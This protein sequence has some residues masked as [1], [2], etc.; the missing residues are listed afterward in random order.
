MFVVKVTDRQRD[1]AQEVVDHFPVPQIADHFTLTPESALD[2]LQILIGSVDQIV[3]TLLDRRER[4]GISYIVTGR[5]S[6]RL[7]HRHAS[8]WQVT[9]TVGLSPSKRGVREEKRKQR[10]RKAE[11]NGSDSASP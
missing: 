1:A 6:N 10:K 2:N 11:A 9:R 8:R 3:E 5:A 4:F 7:P